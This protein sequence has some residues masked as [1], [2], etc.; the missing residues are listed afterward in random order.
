MSQPD[1][2]V[3]PSDL[4]NAF[5]AFSIHPGSKCILG[6]RYTVDSLKTHTYFCD[7]VITN[8]T[9]LILKILYILNYSSG[10]IPSYQF[11]I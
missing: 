5:S 8:H 7:F 10:P 2:V 1:I 4:G 9:S 11:G 6:G 3:L